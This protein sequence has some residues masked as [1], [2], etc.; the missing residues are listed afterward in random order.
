MCKSCIF[1][2]MMSLHDE[3]EKVCVCMFCQSHPFV[4]LSCVSPQKYLTLS[5]EPVSKEEKKT[6]K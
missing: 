4:I 5:T 2:S 1:V 3:L 6:T